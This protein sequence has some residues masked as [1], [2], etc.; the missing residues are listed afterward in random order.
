MGGSGGEIG[1][2]VVRGEGSGER[3]G[4]EGVKEREDTKMTPGLHVGCL[5][6]QRS[7]CP[8]LGTPPSLRG[9]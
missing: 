5:C 2:E 7:C 9:F 4:E 1:K 3:E 6:G 8:K